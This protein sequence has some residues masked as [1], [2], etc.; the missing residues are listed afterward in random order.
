MRSY[1]VTTNTDIV[2]ALPVLTVTVRTA[3]YNPPEVLAPREE[4]EGK[5]R[6]TW[7]GGKAVQPFFK[8]SGRIEAGKPVKLWDVTGLD[9]KKIQALRRSRKTGVTVTDVPNFWS[10]KSKEVGEAR[11]PIWSVVKGSYLLAIVPPE[12]EAT[13]PEA[14]SGPKTTVEAGVDRTYR[15]LYVQLTFDDEARLV[16]A[17]TVLYEK[18]AVHPNVAI[19]D[20]VTKK[21]AG[22]LIN[23]GYVTAFSMSELAIDWKPDFVRTARTLDDQKATTESGKW[24]RH[25]DMI[26]VHA[27]GGPQIGPALNTALGKLNEPKVGHPY[28][29]HYELDLDGHNLKFAYDDAIVSHAGASRFYDVVKKADQK[30]IGN[31]SIGIEVVNQAAKG[32]KAQA[33]YPEP[34]IRALTQLL[35]SLV[36]AHPDV[37]RHRVVGHSDIA[38]DDAYTAL[39]DRRIACPGRNMQWPRLEKSRLGRRIEERALTATDYSNFFSLTPA[40]FPAKFPGK[41]KGT[42][43]YLR[44]G[45]SDKG[46]KWGGVKWSTKEAEKLLADRG[47]AFKD[48]VRELQSDLQTLGYFIT[49]NGEFDAKTNAALKHCIYHTF[50]GSRR[51]LVPGG[52]GLHPEILVNPTVARYLKGGADA[53]LADVAAAGSGGGAQGTKHASLDMDAPGDADAWGDLHDREEDPDLPDDGPAAPDVESVA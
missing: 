45:D 5:G 52:N 38:T 3:F 32:K 47:L 2:L 8:M 18:E 25:V 42:E 24:K 20:P 12:K 21:P 22:F 29:P 50:S 6:E 35:E 1:P 28:G 46:K 9:G 34:Q 39:S 7:K 43:M 48:I 44:K 30:G 49:V 27:T 41:P 36:A 53:V 23:H 11:I 33:E 14:P 13:K 37:P 17:K 16:E 31:F 15:P 19:S 26:V 40:D 10:F 4:D 51:A